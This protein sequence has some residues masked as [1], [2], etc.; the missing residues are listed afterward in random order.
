MYILIFKQAE[1]GSYFIDRN[2]K[3]FSIILEYFRTGKLI[4]SHLNSEQI[5]ALHIELDYYQIQAQV[6]IK[7]Y[8]IIYILLKTFVHFV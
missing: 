2:P 7:K 1:G 6:F 4:T 5:E 3:Y 8:K